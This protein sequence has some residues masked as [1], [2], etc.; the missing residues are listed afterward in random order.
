MLKKNI[1]L[2]KFFNNKNEINFQF[3]SLKKNY[4]N[5]FSFTNYFLKYISYFSFFKNYF[6]NYKNNNLKMFNFFLLKKFCEKNYNLLCQ[7][8]IKLKKI[9]K[10]K[11]NY[12][13]FKNNLKKKKIIHFKLN[14]FYKKQFNKLF[15]IKYLYLLKNNFF[16]Q[17]LLQ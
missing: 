15:F 7:K 10:K 5:F 16:F 4:I 17:N 13:F 12:F 14:C 9:L 2:N 3:S 8:K 1:S 11:N 6:L